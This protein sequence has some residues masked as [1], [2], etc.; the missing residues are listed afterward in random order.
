MDTQQKVT[1]VMELA[2][3]I[4]QL[5]KELAA[6]KEEML[7]LLTPKAADS[8]K[9]R[10]VVKRKVPSRKGRT[11]ENPKYP[12]PKGVTREQQLHD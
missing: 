10:K 8:Q 5:E 7:G 2:G 9:V 4:S 12:T 3:K 11:R 1:K 6:R